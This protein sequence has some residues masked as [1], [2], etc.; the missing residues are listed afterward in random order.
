MKSAFAALFILATS[1]LAEWVTP[2]GG[3]A[4]GWRQT[5]ALQFMHSNFNPAGSAGEPYFFDA[6]ADLAPQ[7]GNSSSLRGF[8]V[9]RNYRVTGAS[10]TRR[11]GSTYGV[12]PAEP[13]N[14]TV[15]NKTLD[16]HYL[17]FE[18]PSYHTHFP[19]PMVASNLN[20]RLLVGH[21]YSIAMARVA[22]E[23]PPAAVRNL[24]ALFM[25]EE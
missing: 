10:L 22:W 19:G 14:I 5:L 18:V 7:S 20:I 12:N 4:D 8:M 21:E 25:E 3:S 9:P 17:L 11:V 15:Y 1:S 16:E 6:P 13:I 23:T 24:V 2:P